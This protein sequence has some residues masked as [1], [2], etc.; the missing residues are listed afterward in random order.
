MTEKTAPDEESSVRHVLRAEDEARRQINQAENDAEAML[1]AARAE[2]RRIESAA[3]ERAHAFQSASAD[4]TEQRVLDLSA[5]A[6][7]RLASIEQE[8]LGLEIRA[9]AES[10]ARELI[11][12]DDPAEADLS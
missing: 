11:R 1:E 5:A 12:F 8:E 10:I 9:A 2:A 4:K 6:E 7:Q 3:V